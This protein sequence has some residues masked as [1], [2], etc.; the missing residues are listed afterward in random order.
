[1]LTLDFVAKR[2]GLLPS[3][4][5]TKGTTFD[6]YVSDIAVRYQNWLQD[7]HSGKP[8]KSSQ[9]NFGYSQEQ[10]KAMLDRARSESA[11]KS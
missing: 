9:Q 4:V 10:L 3:E 5:L 7:K 2:Y 8:M 1:M 6:L 11:D